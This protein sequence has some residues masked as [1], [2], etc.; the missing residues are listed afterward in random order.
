MAITLAGHYWPFVGTPSR[1]GSVKPTS[2]RAALPFHSQHMGSCGCWQGGMCLRSKAKE[3]A[4]R[5]ETC[6]V[7]TRLFNKPLGL[8]ALDAVRVF[9]VRFISALALYFQADANKWKNR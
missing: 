6:D 4:V 3:P 7:E 1:V 8:E 9:P 2:G 5:A